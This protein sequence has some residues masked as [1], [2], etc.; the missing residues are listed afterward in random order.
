MARKGANRKTR[1]QKMYARSLEI[2]NARRPEVIAACAAD[3]RMPEPQPAPEEDNWD[4]SPEAPTSDSGSC[5]P[6]QLLTVEQLQDHYSKS[7][8]SGEAVLA[9]LTKENAD[10]V[11]KELIGLNER[12][13]DARSQQNW[14]SS[15]ALEQERDEIIRVA[16]ETEPT[17]DFNT[18]KFVFSALKYNP[19]Y[20]KFS[21][22]AAKGENIADDKLVMTVSIKMPMTCTVLLWT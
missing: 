3:M 14:A 16:R 9:E 18:T 1:F 19:A 2:A 15:E 7:V 20:H 22:V 6:V 4:A 8:G 17:R 13:L 12:I 21:A 11:D 5:A 10:E